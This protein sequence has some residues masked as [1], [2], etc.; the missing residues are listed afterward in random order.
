MKKYIERIKSLNP[1]DMVRLRLANH[2]IGMVLL[3]SVTA[4]Y[5][6]TNSNSYDNPYYFW[7]L[8]SYSIMIVYFMAE[9]IKTIKIIKQKKGSN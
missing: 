1:I 9:A 7:V 5:T 4:G 3:I 2:Q 8:I 6:Y